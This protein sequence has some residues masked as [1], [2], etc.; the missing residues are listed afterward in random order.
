MSGFVARFMIEQCY[1]T[2]CDMLALVLV[3]ISGGN[4]EVVRKL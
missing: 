2:A 4:L 1:S 3:R